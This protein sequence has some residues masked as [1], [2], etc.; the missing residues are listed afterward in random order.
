MSRKQK[1]FF[2]SG[3]LSFMVGLAIILICNLKDKLGLNL[4]ENLIMAVGFIG[5]ALV[6]IAMVFVIL[7]LF[8]VAKNDKEIRIEEKDERNIM[9]R[10]KASENSNLITSI[11]MLAIVCLFLVKGDNFAAIVIAIA[12]FLISI[13]HLCFIMYF[14]KNN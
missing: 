8:N 2:V 13:I 5:V 11:L 10:G 9:I 3:V 4:S 1:L 12:M 7:Y 6:I 14:Q